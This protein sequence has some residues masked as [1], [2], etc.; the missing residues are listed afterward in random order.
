MH[1]DP[2]ITNTLEPRKNWAICMDQLETCRGATSFVTLTGKK[3]TQRK[4]TEMPVTEAVIKQVEAIAVKDGAVKVINFNNRK[5]EEYELDNDKEYKMLIEPD[6]P[7][8]F[9]NVPAEAPG[10]LN[11]LEEEY[12][13]GDVILDAPEMSAEQQAILAENNLGL[14]F[15]S[16]PTKVTGGEVIKILNDDKE[17]VMNKY[18]QEE[19]HMKIKPDKTDG[20]TAELVS[21]TRRSDPTR[22]VDRKFKDYELYIPWKKR[23]S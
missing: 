18:K 13:V 20:A 21:N 23:S 3:V 15:S 5:G 16:V 19:V 8:P 9:L 10:M 7:A 14:D 2:D 11:E 22:I 12:S 6:N 4:F 17:E 1:I